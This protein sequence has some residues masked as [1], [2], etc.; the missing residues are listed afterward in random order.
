VD[1]LNPRSYFYLNQ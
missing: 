1:T